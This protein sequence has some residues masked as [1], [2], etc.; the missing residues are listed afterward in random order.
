MSWNL[1]LIGKRADVAAQVR[2]QLVDNGNAP[3]VGVLIVDEINALPEPK[4]NAFGGMDGFDAVHVR[5]NGHR[6]AGIGELTVQPFN[7]CL[8]PPVPAD[9][10]VSEVDQVQKTEAAEPVAKE[11][12]PAGPEAPAEVPASELP[13]KA[14]PGS[15]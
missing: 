2:A 13:P 5:G 10:T 7:L 1:F 12:P 3:G 14:A 6:G 8:A 9:K 4:P 11:V 15:Y